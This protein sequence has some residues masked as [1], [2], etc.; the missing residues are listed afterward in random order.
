MQVPEHYQLLQWFGQMLFGPKYC[1]EQ[2]NEAFIG[3]SS[4]L[5]GSS[6]TDFHKDLESGLNSKIKKNTLESFG[7]ITVEL[8]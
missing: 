5:I 3:L 7:Q 8:T 2:M 4:N 6:D 1:N